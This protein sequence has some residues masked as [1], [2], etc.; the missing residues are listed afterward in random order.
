MIE[1]M[2]TDIHEGH[3]EI[4]EIV[5]KL[6]LSTIENYNEKVGKWLDSGQ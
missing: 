4:L 3:V 6:Y 5:N 1:Y 2:V